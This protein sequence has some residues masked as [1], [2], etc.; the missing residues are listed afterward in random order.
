MNKRPWWPTDPGRRISVVV[1]L[2][3]SS[4]ALAVSLH[5]APVALFAPIMKEYPRMTTWVDTA[6]SPPTWPKW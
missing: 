4:L 3:L 5:A 1:G 6:S 2:A